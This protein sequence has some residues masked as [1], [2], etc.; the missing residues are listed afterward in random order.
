[1]SD[2]TEL[3]EKNVSLIALSQRTDHLWRY[4]ETELRTNNNRKFLAF[5]DSR[6]PSKF[7]FNEERNYKI[8]CLFTFGIELN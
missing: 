7:N 8:F 3:F 4:G 2:F 1:M 6:K 5:F